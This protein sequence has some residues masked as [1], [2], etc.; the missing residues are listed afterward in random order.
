MIYGQPR[1]HGDNILL[2]PIAWVSK[3]QFYMECHLC[4]N[5]IFREDMIFD[6]YLEKWMWTFTNDLDIC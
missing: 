1:L 5:P 4:Q 3:S 6:G 2:Q